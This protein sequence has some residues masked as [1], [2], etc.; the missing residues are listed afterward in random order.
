MNALPATELLLDWQ[1]L[2]CVWGGFNYL[3]PPLPSSPSPLPPPSSHLLSRRP[4]LPPPPPPPPPSHSRH[5][6]P[7]T[8]WI[9]ELSP[10]GG[11]TSRVTQDNPQVTNTTFTGLQVATQYRVRVAV[12]NVRGVG[13]FSDTA[14]AMTK[15]SACW[16]LCSSQLTL[17]ECSNG[18]MPMV[19]GFFSRDIFS[20]AFFFFFQVQP[21]NRK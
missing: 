10:T 2:D 18:G 6:R 12:A 15:V 20:P 8:S 16:V 11:D 9:L 19:D 14:T 1:V 7:I 17:P 13:V 5:H 21:C 4:S 3:P